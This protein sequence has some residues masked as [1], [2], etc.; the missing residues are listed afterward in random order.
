MNHAEEKAWL[1]TLKP[2]DEV[3][4][5]HRYQGAI[6]KIERLTDTQIVIGRDRYRH[7]R[8]ARQS[9]PEVQA[10]PPGARDIVHQ[11]VSI[12]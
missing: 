6:Q 7:A 12:C 3:Y 1:A 4:I 11:P 5:A 8:R 9:L 2:G 10:L